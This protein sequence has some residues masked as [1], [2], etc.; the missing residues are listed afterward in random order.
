MLPAERPLGM[1]NRRAVGTNGRGL[2]LKRIKPTISPLGEPDVRLR[3][4][5]DPEHIRLET[6][7]GVGYM[8][9]PAPVKP[10]GPAPA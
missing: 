9:K 5:V 6:V 10:A 1:R 2:A 8:F 7:R 3:S 4:K